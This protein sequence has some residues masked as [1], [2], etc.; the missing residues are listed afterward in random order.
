MDYPVNGSCTMN[1]STHF[2]AVFPHMHQLGRHIRVD[3]ETSGG[4][5]N[6]YDEDYLFEAQNFRE[7]TPIPLSSGDKILVE[8]TFRND[9]GAPVGFGES[10][11]EEMCFAISYRYPLLG[12]G[13]FNF[14]DDTPF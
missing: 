7:V 13:L 14:C 9:T 10:S 8:C 11:D 6:I 5:M 2:F 4:T 3:L 1:G 12:S